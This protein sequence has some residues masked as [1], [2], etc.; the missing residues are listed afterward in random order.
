M[1]VVGSTPNGEQALAL[2][3]ENRP[4]VVLMQV[5][6]SFQRARDLLTS[7]CVGSRRRRRWS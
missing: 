2:A 6:M 1:R 7:G 4:D 5:Q 3:E